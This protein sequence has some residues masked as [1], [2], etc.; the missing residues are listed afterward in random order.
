MGWLRNWIRRASVDQQRKE[1]ALFIEKLR[2]LDGEEL[3]L[4]LAMTT[5]F[6]HELEEQ[7]HN[8]MDMVGYV[9]L[10]PEFSVE[11]S[12]TAAALQK[13]GNNVAA[14]GPI[15]W[16]HT[17]RAAIS[18]ELRPLAREMW[19]HLARGLPYVVKSCI[20]VRQVSGI[21]LDIGGV[22]EFPIGFT[23]EPL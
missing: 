12:R 17:A 4:P 11:L 18:P 8:P 2:G 3:A 15:V 6:R 5:H 16:C 22:E 10:R 13:S 7:G 21:Y 20:N 14:V 1:I 23:P 9:A 19:C